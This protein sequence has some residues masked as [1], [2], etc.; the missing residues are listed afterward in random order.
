MIISLHTTL[1]NVKQIL[2]KQRLTLF[3]DAKCSIVTAYTD[4]IEEKLVQKAIL[5]R[6]MNG[7]EHKK[8]R[9]PPIFWKR[10]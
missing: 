10:Y 8:G 7:A 2:Q 4:E 1:T 9:M 5:V 3:F 6:K